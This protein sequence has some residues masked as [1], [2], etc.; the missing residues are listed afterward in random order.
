MLWFS[1]Y[2]TTNDAD[3]EYIQEEM[4]RALRNVDKICTLI[5][6]YKLNNEQWY[7]TWLDDLNSRSVRD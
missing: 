6:N 4:D 3:L 5:D 7:L 1:Q 2:M